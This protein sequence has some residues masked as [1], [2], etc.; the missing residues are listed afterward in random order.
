MFTFELQRSKLLAA[1]HGTNLSE[2]NSQVLGIFSIVHVES[3]QRERN[4][5]QLKV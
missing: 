1:I 3:I 2:Y 4:K 5:E